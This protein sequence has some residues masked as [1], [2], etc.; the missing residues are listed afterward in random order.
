MAVRFDDIGQNY[1]RTVSLGA[2]TAWSVS[3]WMKVSTDRNNFS[4]MWSIASSTTSYGYIQ[5]AM[6]GLTTGYFDSTAVTQRG[7]RAL[8]LGTWYW[9]GIA[10]NGAAG[11]IYSRSASDATTT[12]TTWASGGA[13]SI[14]QTTLLLGESVFTNE[15]LNGCIAGFKWWGAIL[16]Q[17]ELENESRQ[18]MPYRTTNL[19]AWYPLDRVSTVDYS[20]AG[21][22]LSGGTGAVTEDGPGIPWS[23]YPTTLIVPPAAPAATLFSGWGVHV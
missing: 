10:I 18:V 17:Q 7:A 14:T 6:D 16:T 9:W 1:T 13:P 3:C 8:T 19:R 11:A 2:Q 5:T 12:V 21:A 23:S 22:A 4:T 20:S 15:W